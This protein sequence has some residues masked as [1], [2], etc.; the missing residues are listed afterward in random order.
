MNIY[1]DPLNGFRLTDNAERKESTLMS[2]LALSFCWA[3]GGP[4]YEQE[5][6]WVSTIIRDKFMLHSDEPLY[7]MYLDYEMQSPNSWSDKM[8]KME[9]DDN[10]QYYEM[11]VP[12]I[13]I[14]K[15]SYLMKALFRN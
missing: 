15:V 14:V 3:F 6:E 2:A 8:E 10:L 12:T 1:L 5:Q 9:F 11:I 7:N 13:D 4:L